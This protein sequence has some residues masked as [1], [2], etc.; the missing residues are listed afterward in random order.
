MMCKKGSH[1]GIVISFVIFMTFAVFLYTIAGPAIKTEKSDQSLIEYLEPKMIEKISSN[2]TT[3]YASSSGSDY[4]CFEI[5]NYPGAGFNTIAKTEKGTIL[6]QDISG[7]NLYLETTE[8]FVKVF[9]SED[10]LKENTF[11]SGGCPS[12]NPTIDFERTE[13]YISEAKAITL[14]ND[15]KTDYKNSR[16]QF[17][18]VASK[19]F[20]MGFVYNNGT[21]FET[22]S[23]DILTNIYVE[24]IPIQYFD[25]EANIKGGF[26]KIKVW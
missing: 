3:I 8:T 15:L 19:D 2:L 22:K 1:I 26:L 21:E 23:P 18:F 13:K 16:V 11:D 17:N 10:S 4:Y 24:K 7:N 6:D 25:N 14:I 12:T 5:L 9:Y 20:G